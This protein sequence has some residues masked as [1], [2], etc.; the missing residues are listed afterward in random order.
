MSA[1][2]ALMP[3]GIFLVAFLLFL[4]SFDAYFAVLDFNHL[5]AIRRT[6]AS[7]FFLRIFDPSD[8][9]RAIIGTG[10]LYR[11]I[12]Y[13]LFWFE[14]QIFG[15][16]PTPYYV[17]NAALHALN[18]VLVWSLAWRLTRSKLASA[19]GALIWAFHPQYADAVAWVSSTTDLLLVFFSLSAL[20][21]YARGLDAEGRGRWLAFGGAFAATLLAIGAKESGVVVVPIIVGY[22][23]LVGEPDWWRQRRVPWSLLPFVLVPAVYFPLRALFVGNLAAEGESTFM[24]FDMLRNVQRLTGLAAGPLVGQTVS[25]SGYGV[26]QGAAGV[27]IIAFTLVMALLGSRRERFLAGWY[28]VA[29][30]PVLVFPWTWLIGR[31]LYLP[32]V[33]LAILTGIAVARA[34]E[35]VP[36]PRALALVRPAAGVAIVA[37]ALVWLGVLN[38]GYQDWLTAKGAD[39]ERF[40]SALK[41]AHPALPEDGRLIVTEAPRSLSLTPD[42]G[43]MLGPAVRIAYGRDVEVVTLARL[44]R[45]GLPLARAYDIWYPP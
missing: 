27:G 6:D 43:M 14:Y 29:L 30:V 22:H 4:P 36:V 26:G 31:Y 23:L 17:F 42:D 16:D 37:G 20:L 45:E 28:Y 40:I 35:L 1:P 44:E 7:T 5:D 21:L 24:T 15:A 13:S 38:V 39:A 34:V 41:E 19:A 9:G 3:A 8:G 10:N 32:T 2:R 25:N 11:P 12:Y 18:A 33:G